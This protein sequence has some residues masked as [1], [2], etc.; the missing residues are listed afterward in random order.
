MA[1][2]KR[3][4]WLWVISGSWWWTGRPGVLQSVRS[5]RVG[6]D[7]VTELNWIALQNFAVFCQT[8]TWI[9]HR[10]PERLL[11]GLLIF[12]FILPALSRVSQ[13]QHHWHLGWILL[14]VYVLQLFTMEKEAKCKKKKCGTILKCTPYAHN[15]NSKL[16]MFVLL[17]GRYP[18]CSWFLL[19]YLKSSYR[20]PEL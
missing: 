1:S 7:W 13:P 14:M 12:V 18:L 4:T 8:S 17:W 19:C 3:R 5:Q 6:H 15:L 9:S 16:L 10:C 11:I 20:H 2:R